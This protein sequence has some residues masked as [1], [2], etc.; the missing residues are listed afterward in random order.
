MRILRAL[1]PVVMVCV[2]MVAQNSYAQ[3][4]ADGEKVTGTISRGPSDKRIPVA[5]PS[6][7]TAPGSESLG[8]DMAQVLSDDLDFTGLIRV[9]PRPEF[10]PGLPVLPATPRRSVSTNGVGPRRTSSFMST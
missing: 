1:V 7:V 10:P 6:F 2:V 3:A 9:M 8:A 5:V 4:P